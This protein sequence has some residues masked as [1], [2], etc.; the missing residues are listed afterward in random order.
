MVFITLLLTF[1]L[2][3]QNNMT[4]TQ[5]KDY[6]TPGRIVVSYRGYDKVVEFVEQDKYPAWYVIVQEC[7]KDGRIIGEPRSHMTTPTEDKIN[8]TLKLNTLNHL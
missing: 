5:L 8:A 6:F 2:S 1:D 4:H 3:N 7:T